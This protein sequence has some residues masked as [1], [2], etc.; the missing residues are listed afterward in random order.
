MVERVFYYDE[1]IDYDIVSPKQQKQTQTTQKS[2]IKRNTEEFFESE[3][4]RLKK[5]KSLKIKK[6]QYYRLKAEVEPNIIL[7]LFG[8]RK[9]K[10]KR[11]I[12]I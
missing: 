11:G 6:E 1:I 5:K 9:K 12:L 4:Q 10:R 8:Y 3:I 2:L 7:T